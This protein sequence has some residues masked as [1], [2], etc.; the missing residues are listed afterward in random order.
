MSSNKHSFYNSKQSK[1][2]PRGYD[3]PFESKENRSGFDHNYL[4]PNKYNENA[5]PVSGKHKS[6]D[7]FNGND[8]SG[9]DSIEN[10]M[11]SRK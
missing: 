2:G 11:Q 4:Y 6:Y 8:S 1:N 5:S 3:S 9:L 10:L 7:P